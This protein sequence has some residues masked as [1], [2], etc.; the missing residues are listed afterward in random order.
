MKLDRE[1][2]RNQEN[3]A[4]ILEI[5]AKE[6]SK[7]RPMPSVSTEITIILTDINDETPKFR[8]VS[9]VAEISESAQENTPLTFIGETKNGVFDYDQVI[10]PNY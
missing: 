4:Y 8:S 5:V 3:G 7:V 1:D 2:S 10:L 6:R 9:Y